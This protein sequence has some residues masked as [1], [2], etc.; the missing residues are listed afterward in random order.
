MPTVLIVDDEYDVR[1][2]VEFFVKNLH[3]DAVIL[4]ANDGA[5]AWKTINAPGTAF[6]LVISDTNMPVMTG[7]QLVANIRRDYPEVYVILMSGGT[8]PENHRAHAFLGKPFKPNDLAEAIR[9]IM[10]N[11]TK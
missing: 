5:D 1:K 2:I 8:E 6:D 3:P 4:H 10:E 11:P 9:R 7:I